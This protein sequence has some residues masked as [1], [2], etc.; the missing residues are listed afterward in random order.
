MAGGVSKLLRCF[1]VIG[2]MLIAS[3]S[4]DATAQSGGWSE[5][6]AAPAKPEPPPAPAPAA[7][8]RGVSD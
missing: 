4:A 3:W 6:I 7:P 8:A 5:P 2:A 1:F